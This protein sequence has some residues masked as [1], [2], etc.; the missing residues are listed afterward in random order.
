MHGT[1]FGGALHSVLL[2]SIDTAECLVS[3]RTSDQPPTP[4]HYTSGH[5]IHEA[6]ETAAAAA[7]LVAS[8]PCQPVVLSGM[9]FIAPATVLSLVRTTARTLPRQSAQVLQP[10]HL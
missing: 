2:P 3:R 9:R 5:I 8:R 4:L 10:R 6:F 1:I 7:E